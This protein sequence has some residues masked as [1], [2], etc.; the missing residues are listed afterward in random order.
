MS[1][2]V[3]GT[4]H[5]APEQ[6]AAYVAAQTEMVARARAQAGCLDFAISEDPGEP[7]RVNLF[8]HWESEDHLTAWRA[9]A[10]PPDTGIAIANAEVFKHTVSETGPPF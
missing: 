3:A 7:G 5:V 2:I 4:F 10:D 1:V 6:R 9:V 8:E